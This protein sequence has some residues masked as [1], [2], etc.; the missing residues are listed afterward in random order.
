[1]GLILRLLLA[2]TIRRRT[3]RRAVGERTG[4][5]RCLHHADDCCSVIRPS[6]GEDVVK[7]SSAMS[8]RTSGSSTASLHGGV[9]RRGTTTS[10]RP[11][12]SATPSTPSMPAISFAPGPQAAAAG[13]R[14]QPLRDGSAPSATLRAYGYQLDAKLD[15][16]SASRRPM[17]PARSCSA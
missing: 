2:G 17:P 13:L 11:V 6:R 5:P 14:D 9:R 7:S 8:A 15:A 10:A 12:R 3:D 16:R 1:M 4:G